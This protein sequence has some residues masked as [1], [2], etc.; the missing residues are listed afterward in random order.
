[1][2]SEGE[3]TDKVVLIVEGIARIVAGAA[4]HDLA[5]V[6][7]G[8]LVGEVSALAGGH[9]TATVITETRVVC[10]RFT[11]D[12]FEQLLHANPAFAEVVMLEAARRLERRHMLAF[13]ERLL[14]RVDASVIADFE[15]SMD[16]ISLRAG[17]VLFHR[18]EIADAGY[19]LIS[20]RL[21][22]SAP[23][24]D[25]EM[26]VV[27]EITRDEIVGEVGLFRGEERET[28]VVAARD[29]RLVKIDLAEFLSL[30]NRHPSVLVPVV[31][32]LARRRPRNR[33][34]ARQR[35]ISLTFTSVKFCR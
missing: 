12:S 13:L 16:W 30:A 18:G 10:H 9:R 2:L 22:E 19:F 32:G 31:A 11:R 28:T 14:G 25:G 33:Q 34:N 21:Q 23:D 8:D 1:M 29:S 35:T 27:R 5:R 6:S 3:A 20:G 17:E 26:E 4:E 7:A 15:N 24:L